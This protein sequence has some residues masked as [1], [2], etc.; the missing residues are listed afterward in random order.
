[1]LLLL[2]LF[3]YSTHSL[4][5][6]EIIQN[7]QD[8]KKKIFEADILVENITSM[9][10]DVKKNGND[11]ILKNALLHRKKLWEDNTVYY[12]FSN[13]FSIEEKKIILSAMTEIEEKTC[14][15]FI[16]NSNAKNQIYIFKGNGCYS[17]VGRYGGLQPLS[18]GWGCIHKGTAMHEL[19]H[20]LG[21]FHEQSRMDRDNYIIIQ[22]KN[23]IEGTEDNFEKYTSKLIDHL[24]QEYDYYSI[25]H[26]DSKAFSKNYKETII[27]KNRSV[28]LLHSSFKSHITK[29]DALKINILYNCS[30]ICYDKSEF[31]KFW[32]KDPNDEKCSIIYYKT[33]CPYSCSKSRICDDELL[34]C[35]DYDKN[36]PYYS[37]DSSYSRYICPKFC[38]FCK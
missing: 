26:Y 10:E 21:F 5:I 23:I 16:E 19:M 35:K 17:Y 18:L 27:P 15:K 33:A 25:L 32:I 2:L 12:N 8:I 36:C 3:I 13:H 9:K 30:K 11:P 7:D 22:W 20:A 6:S 29:T 28:V 4:T 1:M 14:I 38:S 34:Q 24:G 31:C 37:C